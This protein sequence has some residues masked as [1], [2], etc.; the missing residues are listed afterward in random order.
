MNATAE[1]ATTETTLE[2]GRVKVTCAGC[3]RTTFKDKMH[4]PKWGIPHAR[5]CSEVAR[6]EESKHADRIQH[7]PRN[8][9]EAEMMEDGERI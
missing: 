8:L 1:I 6:V 4:L 9:E 7:E 3:E 5:S 2:G